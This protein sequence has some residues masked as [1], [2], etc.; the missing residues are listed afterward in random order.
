[1]SGKFSLE[2]D[3]FA[4]DEEWVEQPE[5]YNE[6][7]RRAALARKEH[8][9][10]KAQLELTSAELSDAIRSDPDSFGLVKVT[11]ASISSKILQ[12]QT[13]K[14][15]LDEVIEKRHD[16]EVL[17]GAL[18]AM[19]HR[20]TALSKLVDLHLSSYYSKPSASSGSREKMEE[21]EKHDARQRTKRRRLKMEEGD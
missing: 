14:D 7:A 11:E 4:L 20:K 3:P 10:A 21:V 8:D 16:L 5:R 13:Y 17:Q 2:I 1:M 6:L 19:D 9:E 18:T 15:A 12:Q